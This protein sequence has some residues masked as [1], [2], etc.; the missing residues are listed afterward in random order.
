MKVL[1]LGGSGFVG[2]KLVNI[3]FN[4]GYE[5]SYTFNKTRL[6]I[7]DCKEF[8]LDVSD[9]QAM[10]EIVKEVNPDVV[11]HTIALRGTDLCETNRGPAYK[12]NVE[13][14]QN[15]ID[16]CKITNSF[17]VYISTAAVFDG[18]QKKIF[19]ESDKS[20][21]V[22]YYAKTKL[23]G[24]KLISSSNLP[25]LIIRTDQLYGWTKH[26]Q[27]ENTVTKDLEKLKKG[28]EVYEIN[29]WYNNPTLADNAAQVITKL[30]TKRKT[31]IYHVVGS[32]FLNRVEWGIKIAEV[33]GLDKTLIKSI[34]SQKL[35]LPAKRANANLSN[36]KVQKDSGI[37]LLSVEEG[38]KFMYNQTDT[39]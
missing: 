15:I 28:E 12:I 11:I 10:F 36:K 6:K 29:D 8:K 30:I 13:G 35:N 23:E 5:V 7:E 26:G 33:F 1:V 34:N 16:A 25:F 27:H 2:S 39:V 19:T 4:D 22:N 24:E 3:M 20:S 14:T 31:G 18:R 21:P 32:D 38:L 9:R 37:Q 17:I